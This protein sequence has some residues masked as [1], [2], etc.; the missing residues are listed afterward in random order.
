MRRPKDC[1]QH[2]PLLLSS[3]GESGVGVGVDG[4]DVGVGRGCGEPLVRVVWVVLVMV[5]LLS[6]RVEG[7]VDARE[8]VVEAELRRLNM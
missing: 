3:S 8:R 7:A 5:L 4:S 2:R 1:A 6:R